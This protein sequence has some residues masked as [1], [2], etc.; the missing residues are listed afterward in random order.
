M[1][2]AADTR[3]L[4]RLC[5]LALVVEMPELKWNDHE[6]VEC[7][8]VLPETDEFFASHYFKK[9]FGQIRLELTIWQ[10]E[11]LVAL[12][13]FDAT[14]TSAFLD[15]DFIVRDRIEFRN[16]TKFASLRFHDAVLVSSRFWMIYDE[17]KHDLFDAAKIPTKLGF[18]L[19]TY[20][21]LEFKV[22]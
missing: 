20:P 17:V 16:E 15:L 12:S 22:F 4:H 6:V 10:N 8:G 7:L 5:R 18:E 19:S 21:K 14:G 1:K 9:S 2:H 13:L 11:S 3:V